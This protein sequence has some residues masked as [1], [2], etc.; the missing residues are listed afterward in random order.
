[1]PYNG[2]GARQVLESCF[3]FNLHQTA[4]AAK[5]CSHC[6]LCRSR[7]GVSEVQYLE[8]VSS[9]TAAVVAAS[10][11]VSAALESCHAVPRA[12]HRALGTHTP[13]IPAGIV[14]V[15]LLQISHSPPTTRY[16][17]LP[18]N[19]CPGVGINLQAEALTV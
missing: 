15:R 2:W 10:D 16:V 11:D 6:K 19:H 12:L 14:T 1:M 8:D 4:T 18:I 13:V 9:V 7:A 5:S 17:D 3:L